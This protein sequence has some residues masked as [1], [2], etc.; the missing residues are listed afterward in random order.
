MSKLRFTKYTRELLKHPAA[1]GWQAGLTGGTHIVLSHP[2]VGGKVYMSHT[3]SDYR[4][5]RNVLKELKR[6]RLEGKHHG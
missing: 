2:E 3:P 5:K 6:I 4:A 1:Q